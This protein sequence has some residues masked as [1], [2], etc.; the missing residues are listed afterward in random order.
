MVSSTARYSITFDG[1]ISRPGRVIRRS[2]QTA[3]RCA[4]PNLLKVRVGRELLLPVTSFAAQRRGWGAQGERG[5]YIG[6]RASKLASK[7]QGPQ[8]MLD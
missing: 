2:F 7:L 4:D 1:R 5:C 3:V 8:V 6:T